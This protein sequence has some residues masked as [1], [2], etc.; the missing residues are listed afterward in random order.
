MSIKLFDL[1]G[2][3]AVVIGGTSGIGHAIALGLADAGADVIPTSRRINNV[4]ETKKEIEYMGRK[5]LAVSVDVVDK[6]SV[7][8]LINKVISEFDKID[9]LVN[10]AGAHIKKPSI[11]MTEDEWN[12]IL[13][14]NLRGM[15]F[16]CQ[17][18]GKQMIGQND[19]K[20][21]NIAS[22]GS[23]ASL[24]ETTAYCASKAGV[25]MLTKSLATEWAKYNINVNAIAPGVFR[26]PLNTKVLDI[27][28]R[29]EKI[30]NATPMHRL[31]KAEEL[32]GTAIYLASNA[33]NF[34]TG[35]VIAVDGGFL[36]YGI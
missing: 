35:E 34:V 14:I 28:E 7:E 10:S 1:T 33:S 23:Y 18:A 31:G 21:I 29:Y 2:K 11:E 17:S 16:A 8:E 6:K 5:S 4:L 25:V 19:G 30:I 26:T 9:I 24:F 36:S 15:F 32:V 12:K 20:I 3:T 22:L 27:K 13:N